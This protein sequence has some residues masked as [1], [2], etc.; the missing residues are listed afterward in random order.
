MGTI[1][2]WVL[3]VLWGLWGLWAYGCYPC[4]IRIGGTSD[5]A[6]HG[7]DLE[8][9]KAKAADA[10]KVKALEDKVHESQ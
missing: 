10:A 4:P 3:W 1:G 2:V 9:Q 7:Q 8:K 6:A 5:L